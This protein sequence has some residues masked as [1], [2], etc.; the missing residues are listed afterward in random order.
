MRKLFVSHAFISCYTICLHNLII[1]FFLTATDLIAENQEQ[2]FTERVELLISYFT[3]KGFDPS[4][5]IEVCSC[6]W[7]MFFLH[8]LLHSEGSCILATLLKL[9]SLLMEKLVVMLWYAIFTALSVYKLS[10]FAL[11]LCLL[12]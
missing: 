5:Y 10:T 3:K 2:P 6:Y 7:P 1:T 8:M 9:Y 12:L 4:G 11:S